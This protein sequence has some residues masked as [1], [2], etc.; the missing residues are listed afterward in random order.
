VAIDWIA[1]ILL[2]LVPTQVTNFSGIVPEL[3]KN[4]GIRELKVDRV[5]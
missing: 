3:L 1:G 5:E 4:K 2:R